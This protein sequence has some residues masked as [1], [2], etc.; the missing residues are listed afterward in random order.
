MAVEVRRIGERKMNKKPI[1]KRLEELH[2]HL[3]AV[4]HNPDTIMLGLGLN[5]ITVQDI[6][7][8]ANALKVEHENSEPKMRHIQNED[9]ILA[10]EMNIVEKQST[11]VLMKV[12][13]L[14]RGVKR[15]EWRYMLAMYAPEPFPEDT[16]FLMSTGRW[17]QKGDGQRLAYDHCVVAVHKDDIEK[18][19]TKFQKLNQAFAEIEKHDIKVSTAYVPEDDSDKIIDGLK[20]LKK[21][22]I[23]ESG[24][25]NK[26]C[27][28]LTNIDMPCDNPKRFLCALGCGRECVG[29][30]SEEAVVDGESPDEVTGVEIWYDYN[31]AMAKKC[32]SYKDRNEDN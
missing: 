2:R 15:E 23:G 3:L 17:Q 25:T 12:P 8:I 5:H 21:D 1:I 26:Y 22:D 19:E 6:K 16:W 29:R 14:P 11:H 4:G 7:D 28:H 13:P 24:T 10:S 18:N 31:K 20:R 30:S 27:V 9:L 32:P